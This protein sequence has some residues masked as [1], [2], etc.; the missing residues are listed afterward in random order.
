MF[1]RSINAG[2]AAINGTIRDINALL[3]QITILINGLK[4][5]RIL[6]EHQ[7]FMGRRYELFL[8]L[9]NNLSALMA[10]D[11]TNQATEYGQLLNEALEI[12]M[13]VHQEVRKLN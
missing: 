11:V 10:L 7:D 5:E 3:G 1:N 2:L 4:T 12:G 9:E 6:R 13:T 8:N